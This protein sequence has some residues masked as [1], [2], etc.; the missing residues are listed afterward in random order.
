V[1]LAIAAVTNNVVGYRASTP[2]KLSNSTTFANILIVTGEYDSED[3]AVQ[4][5]MQEAFDAGIPTYVI[6]FGPL[7]TNPSMQFSD[8]L[9]QMA[10]WGAGGAPQAARTAANEVELFGAV[11]QIVDALQ[12]PCCARI[13]CSAVG[14]PDDTGGA[15]GGED[16]ND[17]WGSA[18]GSG[19]A[20][21]SSDASASGD[22]ASGSASGSGTDSE[23]DSDTAGIDDDG[24]CSCATSRPVGSLGWLLMTLLGAGFLR[25]REPRS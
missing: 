25:R 9:D 14:G 23:T 20:S 5:A 1:D 16:A 21:D 15:T 2:F 22:T 10:M 24:G 4:T 6:G 3:A 11:Q 13:D 8:Q 7:A 17:S 18:S 12:L 19:S